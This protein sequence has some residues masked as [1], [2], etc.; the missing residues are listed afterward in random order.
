MKVYVRYFYAHWLEVDSVFAWIESVMLRVKNA[1]E[2]SLAFC[3]C[4]NN[5]IEHHIL[6]VSKNE[7]FSTNSTHNA[8]MQYP[9]RDSYKIRQGINIPRNFCSLQ[10]KIH[11]KLYNKANTPQIHKAY[12]MKKAPISHTYFLHKFTRIT[13][14]LTLKPTRISITLLFPFKPIYKERKSFETR[15]L[16]GRGGR[17]ITLYAAQ[18]HTR[19]HYKISLG[20]TQLCFLKHTL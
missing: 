18:I 17:I 8:K 2:I 19:V 12:A 1:D 11:N 5:I 7:L 15:A 20:V 14:I 10:N 9:R 6:R 3:E 4:A 16:G 13:C